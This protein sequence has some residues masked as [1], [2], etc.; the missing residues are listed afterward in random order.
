MNPI[1]WAEVTDALSFAV[2]LIEGDPDPLTER[3]L[4]EGEALAVELVPPET[5]YWALQLCDRWYQCF[6]DRRTN[7]N[8]QQVTHEP[9]GSVRI[10]VADGD[11]GRANWLDTGGHRVGIM[12]FRWLHADPEVM[13]TCKVIDRASA[14]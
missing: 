7:L 8:D 5:R 14:G 3:E 13:P 4:G 2:S 6:P 1:P 12:F 9:D 10:F 11:P